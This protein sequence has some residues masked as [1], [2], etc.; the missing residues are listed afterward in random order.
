M[1]ILKL[2]IVH[3]YSITLLHYYIALYYIIMPMIIVH[4]VQYRLWIRYYT[5]SRPNIHVIVLATILYAHGT[6]AFS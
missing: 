3:I 4:I 5:N 1:A 2:C 6:G